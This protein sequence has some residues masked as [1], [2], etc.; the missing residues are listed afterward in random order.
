MIL[1]EEIFI[2]LDESF[3]GKDILSILTGNDRIYVVYRQSETNRISSLKENDNK[4]KFDAFYKRQFFE[5][6]Y[7]FGKNLG[8]DKRKLS[9]ISKLYAENF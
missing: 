4:E 7:T 9:E 1:I 6:A 5:V 2:T 8:Y 3:K